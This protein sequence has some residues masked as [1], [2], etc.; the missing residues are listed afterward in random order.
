MHYVDI[1]HFMDLIQEKQDNYNLCTMYCLTNWINRI[2]P[3]GICNKLSQNQNIIFPRFSP[4]TSWGLQDGKG[5]RNAL[6][7]NRYTT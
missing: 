7:V 4:N 1:L 6:V 2:T 5:L 3:L